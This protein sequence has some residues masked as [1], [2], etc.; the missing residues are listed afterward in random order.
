MDDA[1]KMKMAIHGLREAEKRLVLLANSDMGMI[2]EDALDD[3]RPAIEL[4]E[5]LAVSRADRG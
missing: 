3:L 2:A 5:G 1:Y 4:L